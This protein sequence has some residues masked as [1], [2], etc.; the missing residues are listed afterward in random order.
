MRPE[1]K[2]RLIE[3]LI[4]T[5]DEEILSQVEAILEK[6]GELSDEHKKIL[7]ERLASHKANPLEGRSWNE[8]KEDVKK[9]L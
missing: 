7:D 5:E 2:Y 8:V 1:I 9:Q 4:Q 3:K 6:T